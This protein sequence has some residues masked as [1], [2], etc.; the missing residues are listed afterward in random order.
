MENAKKY[1]ERAKKNNF[2]RKKFE[3]QFSAEQKELLKKTID[4]L[5]KISSLD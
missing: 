5:L 3:R 2:D 1:L 4:G